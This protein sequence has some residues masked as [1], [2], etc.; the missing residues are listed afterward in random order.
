MR[1]WRL[2]HAIFRKEYALV[3]LGQGVRQI[4]RIYRAPSGLEYF[5]GTKGTVMLLSEA[6]GKII[7]LTQKAQGSGEVS[8]CDEVKK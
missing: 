4:K 7:S 6:P 1:L 3:E 2:W 5:K 8:L